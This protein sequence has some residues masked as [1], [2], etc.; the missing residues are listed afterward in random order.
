MQ[1]PVLE[2]LVGGVVLVGL[3]VIL[4]LVIGPRDGGR[5]PDE[6]DF[7]N[8]AAPVALQPA[9]PD[10]AGGPEEGRHPPG[11]GAAAQRVPPGSVA[12]APQPAKSSATPPPSPGAV[13]EPAGPAAAQWGV[14]LGSFANRGNAAALSDWCREQGYNVRIAAATKQG[15]TLYRV[16]V[17]PFATR[18]DAQSAKAQLAL[19]GHPSFITGWEAQAP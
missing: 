3:L 10:I 1:S 9:Q 6:E 16:R 11:P 13:A 7:R 17:G 19:Q 5:M 18:G 14:Q 15:G 4:A 2:R 8:P 12:R